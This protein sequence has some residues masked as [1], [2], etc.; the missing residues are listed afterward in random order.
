MKK[1][2][3]SKVTIKPEYGHGD[4]DMPEG[5]PANATLT[6]DI[7]CCDWR[8]RT[9]SKFDYSEEERLT[10]GLEFKEAGTAFFKKGDLDS[11][12]K[13]Y[14][15]AIDF[16]EGH[17]TEDAGMALLALF[18]NMSLIYYKE[19]NF[20]LAVEEATKAINFNETAV[21]LFLII[22]IGKSIFQKSSSIFSVKKV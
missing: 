11:A 21:I 4:K 12:K 8:D 20:E 19:K 14:S 9:K 18:Q 10:V 15:Q 7:I 3:R 16:L 1:G 22:Y 2:E 6:Y 5:V 17:N 13:E